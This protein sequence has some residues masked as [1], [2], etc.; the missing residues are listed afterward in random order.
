MKPIVKFMQV[1]AISALI[2]I[3][4]APGCAHAQMDSTFPLRA[5]ALVKDYVDNELFTGTV[6]V[7][8]NGKPIFRQGFGAANR[9]WSVPN[10]ATTKF[11]LAS[12]SKH[13]TAAAILRLVDENKLQLSDA[14]GKHLPGIPASWE[15]VTVRQLLAHT[16]G[17]P[18]YTG[19]PDFDEKLIRLKHTA[20]Q[21]L[22]LVKD[23]PLY[24]EPGTKYRYS[25]TGYILLGR[26][27][28][29]V[30]GLSFQHYMEQKLL[31][32]LNLKNTGYDDGR[33]ILAFAAQDYTD[34]VDQ[35]VKGAPVDMSNA[36]A[37]GAIY[38]TVDD[39]LAWQQMLMSGQ[40]LSAA[41]T[42]A[43]FSDGGFRNGLG[44]VVR[45]RFSRRVHEHG[46]ALMGF[47]S[48]LANYP[49]DKLTI[50]V[51]SNYGE[52]LVSKIADDLAR[53]AL[54][55][56]PAHR[57]VKV[58]SSLYARFEGRYELRPDLILTIARKG[59]RLFAQA[60]R[61]KQFEI[62]PESEYSYFAKAVDVVLAFDRDVA[63]EIASVTLHQDGGKT[64]AKRIN[65][66]AP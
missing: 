16:S 54:G 3:G 21:L 60:S 56:A 15:K 4:L 13:F 55:V 24:F 49:D 25:N 66:H 46:G 44:W 35:V 6:L 8:Q 42:A 29:A 32:P 2:G 39:V 65:Q 22:D 11:R 58:D 17:I 27:I 64:K 57:Q 37:A 48:M 28:E 47:H 18:S 53:L 50:V 51:L 26:I 30:S 59:D 33:R 9:E 14:I 41:S 10:T 7:A 38:S 45:E 61:Q 1:F 63:G 43:M 5:E 20:A 40:V 62:Y 23:K 52:E 12:T 31:K 36:S 34:G 19:H